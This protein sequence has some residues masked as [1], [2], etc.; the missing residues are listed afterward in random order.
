[1]M[2]ALRRNPA[3]ILVVAVLSVGALSAGLVSLGRFD[4]GAEP[5][6]T[7]LVLSRA[8]SSVAA[9]GILSLWT[10]RKNPKLEYVRVRV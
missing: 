10:V 2:K 5:F 7:L 4:L 6:G 9:L 1:M 8:V 3:E